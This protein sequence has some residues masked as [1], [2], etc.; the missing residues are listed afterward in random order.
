MLF[1]SRAIALQKCM[2]RLRSAWSPHRLCFQ[3][4]CV[5]CAG[6]VNSSIIYESV[7]LNLCTK[8]GDPR[9][10]SSFSV[11]YFFQNGVC[12]RK[13]VAND[14]MFCGNMSEGMLVN[15]VKFGEIRRNRL[16][17]RRLNVKIKMAALQSTG[18]SQ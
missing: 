3:V 18:S 9:T 4:A 2:G 13:E 17:E 5:G 10:S 11:K 16:R 15:L 12:C 1:R 6:A 8:F 14:V 7:V